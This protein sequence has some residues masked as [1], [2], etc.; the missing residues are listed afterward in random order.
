MWAHRAAGTTTAGEGGG[1][2]AATQELPKPRVSQGDGDSPGQRPEV[3][4][5]VC[6][7]S[8]ICLSS[9]LL[10]H[11]LRLCL[12]RA[13]PLSAH[14]RTGVLGMQGVGLPLLS[15]TFLFHAKPVG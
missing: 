15:F 7:W 10:A 1:G 3:T 11:R 12:W 14:V 4:S 6:I 9:L 13:R 2:D 8:G 5:Y